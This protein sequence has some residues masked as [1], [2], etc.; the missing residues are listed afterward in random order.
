MWERS[1]AALGLKPLKREITALPV[2][3]HSARFIGRMDAVFGPSNSP[4]YLQLGVS[5]INQTLPH[6]GVL[7]HSISSEWVWVCGTKCWMLDLDAVSF[8]LR[9]SL[10]NKTAVLLFIPSDD[11]F[12]KLSQTWLTPG[13][14]FTRVYSRRKH[15]VETFWPQKSSH[16][17]LKL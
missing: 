16:K 2:K 15:Q 1:A 17:M 12:F 9:R 6:T 5:W 8:P 10:W 11:H 3:K 4:S 13:S 14:N 7:K